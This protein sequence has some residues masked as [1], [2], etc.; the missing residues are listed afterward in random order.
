MSLLNYMQRNHHGRSLSL[1]LA[2]NALDFEPWNHQVFGF[3][4]FSD[5]SKVFMHDSETSME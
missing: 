4:A 3:P 1:I 2:M 5:V